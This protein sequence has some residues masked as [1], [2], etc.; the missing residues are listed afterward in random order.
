[1]QPHRTLDTSMQ[2]S[3][4]FRHIL[5]M[6]LSKS[7]PSSVN[8]MPLVHEIRDRTPPLNPLKSLQHYRLFTQESPP[9]CV[10]TYLKTR[11]R[12]PTC[13]QRS[14]VFGNLSRSSKVQLIVIAGI[15]EGVQFPFPNF[16]RNVV[17]KKNE[18][19]RFDSYISML[20]RNTIT[21]YEYICN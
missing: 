6:M 5:V 13:L 17:Q 9:M 20:E 12:S 8:N 7:G 3:S 11:R 2:P 1:M 18:M 4:N 16:D 21:C 14:F 15:A 10:I 19:K